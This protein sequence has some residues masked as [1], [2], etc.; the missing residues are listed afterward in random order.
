MSIQIPQDS[1]GKLVETRTHDGVERQV[2]VI[3]ERQPTAFRR[4]QTGRIVHTAGVSPQGDLWN[5]GVG[6]CGLDDDVPFEGLPT[7]RLDTD[8]QSSAGATNP[9]RTAITTGVVAKRRIHD[10]FRH[11]WGMEMW[12]RNTGLNLTSNALLSMSVYNRDGTNATHGRVWLDPNGNNTPL[13][14]RILDGAATFALSGTGGATAVY[15]TAVTSVLQNG[16]GTHTYD[17]PSGRLDR[18]GGW[19][20]VKLIVDFVTG[21]YVSL[22]LDGETVT[23][24]SAYTLDVTTS[25]GFAGMHHSVEFAG[26]TT[27]RRYLHVTPPISTIEDLT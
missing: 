17:L 8:A 10:G 18:A 6:F 23:D 16:A 12:F 22:Q 2:I 24:L 19:H 11:R 27:T 13:V 1:N 4:G 21:R 5:D 7:Y 15:T 3:G 20:W 26:L 14:A 9:G 25:S